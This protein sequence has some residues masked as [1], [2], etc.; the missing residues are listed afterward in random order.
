MAPITSSGDAARSILE[1]NMAASPQPIADHNATAGTKAP[2]QQPSETC[3][4]YFP[5]TTATTSSSGG[6]KSQRS[7]IYSTTSSSSSSSSTAETETPASSL[8][9]PSPSSSS[10]VGS[11]LTPGGVGSG[12]ARALPPLDR[13]YARPAGELDVAAQL[14]RPPAYWSA[15]GWVSRAAAAAAAAEAEEEDDRARRGEDF[16]ADHS[17][18]RARSRLEEAKRELLASLG[19]L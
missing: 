8:S 9:S 3:T 13:Q 14:A 10:S 11:G 18:R 16:K 17:A 1:G 5:T 19:R 2:K 7:S 15:R 6:I 4:S 12:Y